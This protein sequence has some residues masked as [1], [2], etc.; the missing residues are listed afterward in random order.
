VNILL[1]IM[2]TE[3]KGMPSSLNGINHLKLQCHDILKT[4]E[5]YTT[6]F[7]FTRL[8][9]YDHFTPD[10]KLF[11]VMVTHEPSNLIIEFRHVPEQAHVQRG[12]DPITWGVSTRKYLEEWGAW[13]DANGIKRS[14]ILTGIKGWV[15]GCLDPDGRVVR[16]YVDDEE[17]EWTDYPDKDEFWLGSV[18]PNPTSE[19]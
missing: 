18:K 11:A 8:K 4:C 14:K 10:H 12:W 15:A 13:F 5:F 6:I 2:S 3:K 7:P 16:L 19:E 1:A 9:Q 17:H